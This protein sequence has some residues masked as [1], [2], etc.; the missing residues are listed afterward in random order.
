MRCLSSSR[1]CP[2]ISVDRLRWA[3]VEIPAFAGMTK[4][5]AAG[6]TKLTAAGMTSPG[7]A[8]PFV[9]PGLPRDLG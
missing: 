1:A 2:G 8:M 3:W 4:L 6:M 7:S 5:T 9:I